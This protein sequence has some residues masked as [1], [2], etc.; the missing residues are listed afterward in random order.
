MKRQIVELQEVCYVYPDQTTALQQVSFSVGAGETVALIGGNG[1]GKSTLLSL[2]VGIVFPTAGRIAIAELELTLKTAA[3][4]RKNV[5]MVFQNPDDQLFMPTV[6]EDVA[7]GPMNMGLSV[8]QARQAADEALATVG[9]GG[10]ARRSSHRLS[11]GEKR[12]VA[13]A[14]V[15]S[16]SPELLLMDEPTSGLDPWSRRQLIFLL[17]KFNHTLIIATHDLDFALDVC[18]Q[19][20]VMQNGKLVA[21]GPTQ[22]ILSDKALLESC[23]LELPLRF[24]QGATSNF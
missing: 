2:L 5:G 17:Q 18:R 10:L 15:L 24:Q 9:A 13:I 21:G 8:E 16:M 19:T 22:E 1:A 12:A 4:V 20:L 14:S 7:F 3:T 6:A 23:R 11:I